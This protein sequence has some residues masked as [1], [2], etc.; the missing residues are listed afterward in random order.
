MNTEPD[1]VTEPQ[2]EFASLD[3][4]GKEDVNTVATTEPVEDNSE[5]VSS[6]DLELPEKYQGKSLE[7]VVQMHQEAEKLASRNGQ[8]L[9]ELRRTADEYIKRQLSEPL[10]SQ[11]APAGV[12]FDDVVKDPAKAVNDI[13]R[14]DLAQINERLEQRDREEQAV[15][16][17]ATY[18]EANQILDNPEFVGWVKESGL[19]MR[20]LEQG[21]AYDFEAAGELMQL[22][23][24]THPAK[25][26][27]DDKALADKAKAHATSKANA[28]SG[29]STRK[30]YRRADIVKLMTE[31]PERYRELAPEIKKAYAEQRVK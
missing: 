19:R 9:G 5:V 11:D 14:N 23:N 27:E 22:Y 10:P 29:S 17:H 20:L 31:D 7:D 3:E 21:N 26:A 30:V 6:P 1:G 28:G 4:L 12:S 15:K 24:A 18:P 8:E 13:V 2:E 16:F 25:T